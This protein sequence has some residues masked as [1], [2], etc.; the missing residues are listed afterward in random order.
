MNPRLTKGAK[1]VIAMSEETFWILL[2]LTFIVLI[3]KEHQ[4]AI[5]VKD[6]PISFQNLYAAHA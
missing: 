6:F 3:I 5:V 1:D 4:S 2:N